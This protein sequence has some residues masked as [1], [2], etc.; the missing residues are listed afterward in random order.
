MK[1]KENEVVEITKGFN[2]IMA[3]EL[4]VNNL[5]TNKMQLVKGLKLSK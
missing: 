2:S 1:L 4:G 5:N 3:I